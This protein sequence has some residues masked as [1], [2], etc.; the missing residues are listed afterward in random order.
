LHST[1]QLHKGGPNN[2]LFVFLTAENAQ[3]AAIPGR[4]YSFGTLKRA[5]ALGDLESLRRRDRRVLHIHLGR[6]V[7]AGLDRL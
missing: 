7:A 6:N 4:P 1:G 5:Q 2:G 3:D